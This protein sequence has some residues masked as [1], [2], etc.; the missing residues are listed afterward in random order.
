MKKTVLLLA[1]A[2]CLFSFVACSPSKDELKFK[3]EAEKRINTVR[4]GRAL[5]EVEAAVM[6]QLAEEE[7]QKQ[8]IVSQKKKGGQ[9]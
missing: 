9:R 6:R 3:A 8:E 1:V 7:K 2:V 4:E 5:R